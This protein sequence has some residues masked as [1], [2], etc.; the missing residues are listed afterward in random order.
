MTTAYTDNTYYK[1]YF[2]ARNIDVTSQLDA[3]IDAALLVATEYLDDTYDFVG[4]AT[5]SSQTEKWPRS[6]VYTVDGYNI[7]S[8]TIPDRVKQA[9]CELAYLEQTQTG[10]LSPNFNGEVIKSKKEKLGD[11][12][13]EIEYDSSASESYNR[14]YA[15]AIK[16]ID[17]WI[18]GS[19][20]SAR[21]V[22]SL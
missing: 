2:A 13:Q 10:G 14:F 22:R 4:Y 5:T 16:K 6:N 19:G 3:A 8:S 18:T 21:L 12:E 11:L 17:H 7:D 1:A 9:T 20:I 15:K